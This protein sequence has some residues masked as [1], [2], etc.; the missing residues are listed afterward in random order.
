MGLNSSGPR[1]SGELS[2]RSASAVVPAGL[3]LLTFLTHHSWD[4]LHDWFPN[5][6]DT[7]SFWRAFHTQDGSPWCKAGQVQHF[8]GHSSSKLIPLTSVELVWICTRETESAG[9]VH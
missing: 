8:Q 5:A 3:S 4:L 9:V 6:G 2:L 1:K 7:R